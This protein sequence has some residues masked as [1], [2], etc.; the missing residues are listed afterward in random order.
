M[1]LVEFN[2]DLD[3]VNEENVTSIMKECG[4]SRNEAMSQDYEMNW[5]L[6]R[7]EFENQTRCITSLFSRLFL[8]KDTKDTRKIIVKCV[9]KIEGSV[10]SNYSGGFCDVKVKFD[11]DSFINLNDSD[12]KK[13]ALE[14]LMKGIRNVAI[15]KKWN[16]EP[17]ERTYNEI[18]KFEYIN[19]WIW[20]KP[21][22]SPNKKMIAKILLLHEVKQIDIS[23]VIC[24][25]IGNEI[26]RKKVISEEPNEWAYSR[27]LGEIKW[28]DNSKVALI[29][30]KGDR[31]W[32]IEVNSCSN[33]TGC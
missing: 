6:K 1:K 13:T 30:R 17:F 18:L 24:D 32:V 12:K 15:E 14:I 9:Q 3:Y 27:Y 29:N 8:G 31:V 22:K 21:I 23:I 5:K 26:I 19:E 20:K 2:L 33:L 7:R 16:M 11:Y 28:V 25:N 10:T 4:C